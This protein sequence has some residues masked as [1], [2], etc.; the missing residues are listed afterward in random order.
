MTKETHRKDPQIYRNSHVVLIRIGSEPDLY[1]PQA[2]LKE[3]LELPFQ[4]PH[5]DEA[6][7]VLL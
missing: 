7:I 5:F 2:V 3:P 4:D 1:Q 6:A